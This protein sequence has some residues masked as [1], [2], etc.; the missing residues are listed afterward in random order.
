ME[1]YDCVLTGRLQSDPLER[2]FSHYRQMSGGRFLVSL[3]EV[4]KSESIIKLKSLLK[5]NIQITSLSTPAPSITTM[6]DF[7]RKMLSNDSDHLQLTQDSYQVTIYISGYIS[8][9]LSK[10]TQCPTCSRSLNE[11][12]VSSEYVSYLNQGGLTLPC[13]SL[14]HYVESSF[15]LLEV[16]EGEIRS[17]SFPWKSLAQAI[18]NIA[19]VE[20]DS[21]FACVD[22][23]EKSKELVNTIVSNIYF[24][25]LR[26]QICETRRKDQ[27]TA[28]KSNKRQKM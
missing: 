23:S 3:Q 18:L 7:A 2:R 13:T 25:N 6:N 5:R 19:T 27:V 1:G 15:C 9:S 8:L 11:N 17:S 26:K 4:I 24:N 28:F 16:S 10:R 20:W 22:H 12:L 21:N 14:H